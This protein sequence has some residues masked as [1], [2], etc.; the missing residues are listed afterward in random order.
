MEKRDIPGHV[1]PVV[2]CSGRCAECANW[3]PTSGDRETSKTGK[4]SE[5]GERTSWETFC[6]RRFRAVNADLDRQ[7]EA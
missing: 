1:E 4:C 7:E 2:S 6:N 3:K 5:Y